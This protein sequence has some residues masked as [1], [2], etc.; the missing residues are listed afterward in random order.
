MEE[1]GEDV[2]SSRV[3]PHTDLEEVTIA[4]LPVAITAGVAPVAASEAPAAQT[5]RALAGDSAIGTTPA[6]SPHGGN[7]V[8]STWR[9]T[10][11]S[12]V[13]WQRQRP[14]TRSLSSGV[15]GSRPDQFPQPATLRMERTVSWLT[16]KSAANERRLLVA[17]RE[18]TADSSSSVSL[19]GQRA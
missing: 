14:R 9:G 10:G 13:R 8:P 17:A 12:G 15:G 5:A 1:A 18:E 2:T 19:H 11:L 7:P 16:S 6:R 3:G 4:G